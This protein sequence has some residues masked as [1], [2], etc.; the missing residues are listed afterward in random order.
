MHTCMPA[1]THD[2]IALLLAVAAQAS[3][4]AQNSQWQAT[5]ETLKNEKESAVKDAEAS[6]QAVQVRG[7]PCMQSHA[8]L[9]NQ[10]QKNDT[11]P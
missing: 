9:E 5:H 4:D 11:R 1:C 8:A 6:K 3:C 2:R 10:K 7:M